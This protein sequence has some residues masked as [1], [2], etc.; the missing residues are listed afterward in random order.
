VKSGRHITGVYAKN[1]KG[2]ALP[3]FHIFDSTATSDEN[4][5][6]K[7]DWLVGL[8]SIKGRFCCPTHIESESF[9]A[10]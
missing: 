7:M 10:I 3:P 4:F 9:Y 5:C 8:P 1:A 2:E 6:I